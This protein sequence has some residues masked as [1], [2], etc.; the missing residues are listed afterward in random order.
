MLSVKHHKEIKVNPNTRACVAY[1]VAGLSGARG[2][3]VYDFSQSKHISISGSVDSSSVDIY[4]YERSCHVSGSPDNLYD[5]G[6]SAHIQLTVE[7]SQFN[8][9]DYAS[10]KHFSGNV[11]G[12]SISV[13][14][15]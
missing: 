12:N 15:Y 2:S 11:N 9:Y 3:S 7:G 13:Y 5:Y 1:I 14:D 6:N 8:G 10:S 4:D